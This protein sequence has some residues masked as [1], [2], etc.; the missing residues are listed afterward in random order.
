MIEEGTRGIL[1]HFSHAS[2]LLG[3]FGRGK[4]NTTE[5]AILEI[6]VNIWEPG[7]IETLPGF[8]D[9]RDAGKYGNIWKPAQT[10]ES[11]VCIVLVAINDA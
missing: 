10:S 9:Q 5:K 8:L 11:L 4:R 6:F 1:Q 3:L 2:E 7:R